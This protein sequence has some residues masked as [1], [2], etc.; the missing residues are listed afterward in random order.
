NRTMS[1]WQ[2]WWRQPQ[3]VWLR[4]AA[5]QVH[6]WCG[7]A[8]GLYIVML[9]VTGSI[10]VYR[11]ELDRWVATPTPV[12]DPERRRAAKETITAAAMKAFPGWEIVR[13]GERISRRYPAIGVTLARNGEET[14]QIFDPYTG[15]HLGISVTKGQDA[16][17][18]VVSLHDD[19][20]FD[21]E[22]RW[23][24]GVTSAFVTLLVLTGLVVW[25]PGVSRWRRSLSIK[26]FGGWRRFTWD[27]HSA[28][29][30]WLFGFLL[31]W[32]VTGIYLGVPGPFS[33]LL[34]VGRPSDG[35]EYIGDTVLVWMTRMHF[36]RWRVPWLK[37]VWAVL[38]LVPAIMFVTGVLMWWNRVLRPK[39]KG[40][41]VPA[42]VEL[43]AVGK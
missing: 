42:V 39:L 12:F 2:R 21:R 24:N 22:G 30:F 35:R 17:L 36:G 18:W 6:L 25:W 29:G 26:L 28:M 32:G 11:L 23:W 43:E 4:R 9:S 40:R 14:D 10:L 37:A 16:I 20:L 38:G 1:L 41:V 15:E 19:L 3:R 27:L 33:W 8:L 34:E 5:F 7:L 31:I 13:Q